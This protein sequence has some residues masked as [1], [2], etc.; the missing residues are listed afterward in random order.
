MML[1]KAITTDEYKIAFL[2]I[3][4][5]ASILFVHYIHIII[6][7]F[8]GV[9]LLFEFSLTKI[10]SVSMRRILGWIVFILFYYLITQFI[11]SLPINVG[12][13][14][15]ID[16]GYAIILCL[17]LLTLIPS[18]KI[19][20]HHSSWLYLPIT[21]I[22]SLLILIAESAFD[23]PILHYTYNEKTLLAEVRPGTLNDY[24]F[25]VTVFLPLNILILKHH[26]DRTL[27]FLLSC[28]TTYMFLIT[29]S[30][31]SQLAIIFMLFAFG[32]IKFFGLKSFKI[33]CA[34]SV[35]FLLFSFPWITSY[36]FES[37]KHMDLSHSWIPMTGLMR[38]DLWNGLSSLIKNAV[39]LGHGFGSSVYLQTNFNWIFFETSMVPHPHNFMLQ[40]WYEF[41]LLGITIFS[42][43]FLFISKHIQ[44]NYSFIGFMI[45]L[46]FLS[47]TWSIWNAWLMGSLI[48]IIT[49]Y[50]CILA[51]KK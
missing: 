5:G 37:V 31:A 16:A 30:T 8:V 43:L 36:L 24:F 26:T 13:M 17:P 6:P 29:D 15:A 51:K 42:L 9:F 33:L 32:F 50:H 23:V 19:S 14:R 49:I 45:V 35:F 7:F 3:L 44:T 34:V 46:I 12:V 38:I 41:G 21:S 10:L 18:M 27:I 40:I 28:L 47:L 20:F 2:S 1:T 11:L 22:I 48:L 25:M 39:W 4:A